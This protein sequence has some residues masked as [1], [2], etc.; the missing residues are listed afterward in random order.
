MENNQVD[1]ALVINW[2]KAMEFLFGLGLVS[3]V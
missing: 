3:F 1:Q 2:Q